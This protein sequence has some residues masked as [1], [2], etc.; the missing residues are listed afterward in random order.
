MEKIRTAVVGVGMFGDTHARTFFECE[1]AELVWVC[2]IDEE[3]A[4]S[5]A[6]K[7]GCRYTTDPND[8]ANDRSV[9]VVG[10]A[11]PDFA[12]LEPSLIM[13]E[14]GKHLIVE[15]PLATTLEE[16]EQI[17]RAAKEKGIRLMTDFQN[18]WNPPFIHAKQVIESGEVGK[19]V[20]AYIRLA[21]SIKINEW[22]SW[23]AKSG[24]QWFLFP[25]TVDMIRWLFQ[26]EATKVFATGRRKTL[27]SQGIDT[28]DAIQAQVIFEDA[29]ATFETAWILPPSWPGLDFRMDFLGENGKIMVEPTYQN[30]AV[31]GNTFSWPFISGRQD[32]FGH[33]F[34]FFR[35]PLLHFLDCIRKDLPC[36]IDADDGL[37]VTRIIVAIEKSLSTGEIVEIR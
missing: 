34:G 7:Y 22:L 17:T 21:N 30:I 33:M 8:I 14:A 20:S 31:G 2:D 10:I 24:P 36:L 5:A 29:F 23:T 9:Q 32:A 18:R 15:K 1:F 19:P 6:E 16:A 11:T 12:H 13:I 25:H 27:K 28:Y 3:R 26:Q 4:K 35:E 37:E